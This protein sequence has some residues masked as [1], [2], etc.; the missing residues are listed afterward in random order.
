MIA[1]I[2]SFATEGLREHLAEC[3]PP[4]DGTPIAD[5]IE[6]TIAWVEAL[7][8]DTTAL[9]TGINSEEDTKMA[10]AIQYVELKSRW[11]A[12]NTKMNYEM[13][14]GRTPDARDMCRAA[15]VSAFLAHIEPM[16]G[17]SDVDKITEFLAQPISDAA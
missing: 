3:P 17:E 6:S 9:L 5:I 14:S 11:I 2:K 10:I 4:P 8:A 1:N 7:R 15:A 13:F 12:F 16:L